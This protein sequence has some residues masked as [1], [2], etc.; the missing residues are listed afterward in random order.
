M[1]E[2]KLIYQK[3]ADIMKDAPAV[4]KDQSNKQQGYSYRGIDDMY[5][6]L[7]ELF[8]KHQVFYTT[9]IL[10]SE[11]EERQ[12]KS[13]GL[14]MYSILDIEFTFFTIDGSSVSSVVRGEGMDSG[15]KSSNKAMS[16]GLKYALMQL[17]LLPTEEGKKND[18]E[19]HSHEVRP[20]AKTNKLFTKEVQAQISKAINT[21]ALTKIYNANQALHMN[22]D[23]MKA[24]F[25]RKKSLAIVSINESDSMMVLQRITQVMKEEM[26]SDP[27]ISE[28]ISKKENQFLEETK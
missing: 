5:N 27:E 28:A 20:K 23:F 6:S 4:G 21:A 12:T 18:S 16:A 15:D 7:H 2:K 13:G 10:N 1:D 17:L 26:L 22:G 14:L 3:I 24:L 19:R 9:K 25:D 11:R 8:A